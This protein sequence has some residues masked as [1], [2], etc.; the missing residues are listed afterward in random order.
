VT[1]TFHTPAAGDKVVR[2]PISGFLSAGDRHA[3]A[4]SEEKEDEKKKRFTPRRG[5]AECAE[6][7]KEEGRF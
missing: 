1:V 4:T 7:E 5:D 3:C 6:E 2:E